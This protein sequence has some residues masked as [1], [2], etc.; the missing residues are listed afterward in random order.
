MRKDTSGRRYDRRPINVSVRVRD[1]EDP[2][3]G[4]ISFDAADVSQGGA[5]LRS[6]LL[7]DIGEEVEITFSLPGDGRELCA[8]ARVVWTAHK[9][10]IK[11]EPGMGLEFVN[12]SPAD[13]DRIIAYVNASREP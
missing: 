5:F 13:R 8:R 6:D 9:A 11:R 1:I 10:F 4:E 2:S 7:L 12:L 3:H